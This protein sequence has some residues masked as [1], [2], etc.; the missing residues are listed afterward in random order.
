VILHA[1][2]PD[3]D[4]LGVNSRRI[5]S[6]AGYSMGWNGSICRQTGQTS[7]SH[8]HFLLNTNR[9]LAGARVPIETATLKDMAMLKSTHDTISFSKR[10]RA[11][12]LGEELFLIH[13]KRTTLTQDANPEDVEDDHDYERPRHPKK[14]IGEEL[15]E[16]HLKRSKGLEPDYDIDAK[17]SVDVAVESKIEKSKKCR[18]NLR[19]HGH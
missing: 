16:V 8:F 15:F 2:C 9:I 5:S 3:D 6:V 17:S 12:S 14:S 18:Y 13:L 1:T 7:I 10:L 19:N 11:N 4:V